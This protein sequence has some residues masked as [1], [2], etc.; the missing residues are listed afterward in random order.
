MMEE[1]TT[2][3]ML[4]FIVE[5]ERLRGTRKETWFKAMKTL[6]TMCN[7]SPGAAVFEVFA[8]TDT[9][10]DIIT[11]GTERLM[12]VSLENVIP[13]AR[14]VEFDLD[15]EGDEYYAK[16]HVPDNPDARIRINMG[17]GKFIPRLM[18]HTEKYEDNG[19]IKKIANVDLMICLD[20]VW[21]KG[22]TV[23]EV[24]SGSEESGEESDGDETPNAVG[25][26]RED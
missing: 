21:K 23:N 15:E 1:K 25:V 10:R 3:S 22:E 11:R 17:K 24:P 26:G 18:A 5:I 19:E 2:K 8:D 20:F 13:G 7:L 9:R 6:Q 4:E 14:I 12:Q 16:I